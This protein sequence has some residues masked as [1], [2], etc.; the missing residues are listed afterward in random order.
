VLITFLR[1]GDVMPKSRKL[2]KITVGSNTRKESPRDLD[3]K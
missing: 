1:I 2:I 3:R